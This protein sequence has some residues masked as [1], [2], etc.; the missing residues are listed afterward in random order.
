MRILYLTRGFLDYRIPVFKEIDRYIKNKLFVLYSESYVPKRVSNKLKKI[1]GNRAKGLIGER[2]IGLKQYSG[3]ANKNLQLSFHPDI[4]KTI[5]IVKPDVIITNGFGQ[6]T[7][8]AL[9]YK[10]TNSVKIVVCYERTYHTERKAQLFRKLFRKMVVRFV[11]AFSCNGSLSYQYTKS[12][13]VPDKKITIGQMA[14]DIAGLTKKAST[15]SKLDIETIRGKWENPELVFLSAGKL[16]KRKGVNELI[17]SW[18]H[19]EKDVPGDWRL[20]I[21]GDGSMAREL[22][23]RARAMNL[24]KAVFAGSIDYDS[25]ATYYA[26]ADVFVMPTLEDNWSLVVPEAMACGLPILCS[27]YNGCYPELIEP[28]GNG[29]VFDPLNESDTFN[30]LQ[31]CVINR[32]RLAKMGQRSRE[33]VT[34]YSPENAAKAIL[35]ACRLALENN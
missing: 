9:F 24:K 10:L 2:G 35:E 20:V 32:D 17:N 8:F 12:L 27:C 5:K 34:K 15:L 4:I 25:I 28:G 18:S 7:F 6:W 19:L 11:D 33:I 29:W 14:A 23:E 31:R 30:A 21:I 13:G 26:A 16:N 1:I 3:F 22:E